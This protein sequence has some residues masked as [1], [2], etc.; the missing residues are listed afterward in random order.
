ME[1]TRLA[2]GGAVQT[3]VNNMTTDVLGYCERFEERQV[4]SCGRQTRASSIAFDLCFSRLTL[5]LYP[6]LLNIR[7]VEI[8]TTSSRAAP[9]PRRAPL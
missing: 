8:A 9:R 3:S 7:W 1:R 6:P 2:C 4:R 5:L